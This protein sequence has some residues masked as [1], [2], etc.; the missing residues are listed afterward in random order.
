MFTKKCSK[1]KKLK[2]LP[3]FNKRS[4][5]KDGLQYS[6]KQCLGKSEKLRWFN[7]RK[8]ALSAYG[9][10]CQCCGERQENF[11]TFDH[12]NNDGAEHRKRLT[13]TRGG[14]IL[15]W[16]INNNFPDSIQI[17]CYNCNCSRGFRGFCH[18]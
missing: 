13:N 15:Y 12:I 6:C 5:T 3:D 7:L 9:N 16:L 1:C 17:L 11:L 8:K 10:K 4:D 18:N 2:L 14:N